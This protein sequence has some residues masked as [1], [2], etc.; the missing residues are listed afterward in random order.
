MENSDSDE[1][2]RRAGD[3]LEKTGEEEPEANA[4]NQSRI[5]HRK[6][7]EKDGLT[8]RR[9]LQRGISFVKMKRKL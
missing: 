8:I 4:N 6:R 3:E 2:A 1:R 5:D 7:N 9:L